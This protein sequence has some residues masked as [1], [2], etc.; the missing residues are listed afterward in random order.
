MK[1]MRGEL[2]KDLSKLK[3]PLA[4]SPKYDGIRG[5]VKNG[6][7]L[8]KTLKPIPNYYLQSRFGH[9]RF[10]GLDGE[11]ILGDP[12][13]NPYKR[14]HSAVMSY[15]GQ[16]DVKFHVWD[17]WDK[18]EVPFIKRHKNVIER[19][20]IEGE[21]NV[22]TGNSLVVLPHNIIENEET[23]L[24]YEDA[25]LG[26]GYEGVML[27]DIN[28]HYKHGKSTVN[29]GLMM[30]LKRF[31]DSEAEILGLVEKMHNG[32]EVFISED[33]TPKRST[34][35][36]NMIP[37]GVL[38]AFECRDIHTGVSFMCSGF[39]DEEAAAFWSAGDSL[40][41]GII[42]YKYFP[43]GTDKKPRHPNFLGFRNKID[44]SEC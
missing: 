21:L 16:P 6:V 7:L 8:S 38:G 12:A 39:T 15:Q 41:G 18:D 11:L 4:G 37:L 31:K 44:I 22:Y 28:G 10:N 35:K 36:E 43:Y 34:H 2:V 9:E 20:Q 29:Q 27:R 30:K 13:D 23:L 42:K 14:T 33:G 40:K 26:M 19:V 24:I 25:L 5:L 1:P 17:E 32:N 3:Y